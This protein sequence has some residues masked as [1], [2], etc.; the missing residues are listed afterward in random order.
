MSK[1]ILVTGANG[2]VG[3][4]LVRELA[5]RGYEV[6]AVGGR[7]GSD[8]PEGASEYVS[9]DLADP[10]DVAKLDLSDVAAVIHLA[11]LAAVG[12][13]FDAPMDYI[14]ANI[15]FQTNLFQRALEQD[16][17]PRFLIV[18]SGSIYGAPKQLPINEQA[19]VAPSSPYAVSKIGQEL[20]GG[21]YRTRGF[22]VVIARP[23]NHTGPGQG[24]GFIVPDFAKQI[25]AAERGEVD[26]ITVGN[27]EAKRDYSDV[28]D[29]AAAYCELIESGKDGEVYNICS[30][31]SRS[32]Q[33]I[34]DTLLSLSTAKPQVTQD[35]ARMRPS[36][37]PDIYGDTTKL[38]ADT[39]WSP[40]YAF[41][42]SLKDALE[43]WR[44]QA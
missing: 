6:V 25:V 13:S 16:V 26:V 24:E 29:I 11:G 20:M 42:T 12:P 27:L 17:K 33:E 18:S 14:N 38:Q 44:H 10:T 34:L 15:G 30:G 4:H 41:E 36:D 19:P 23:S 22:E 28:R 9:V 43:D 35:P 2:F 32:G 21:Y 5:S 1:R 40:K 3:N 8:K 37:T 39:G 7:R 31:T